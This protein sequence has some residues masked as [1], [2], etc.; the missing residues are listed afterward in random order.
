MRLRYKLL[1][2]FIAATLTAIVT[3]LNQMGLI[4]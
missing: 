3:A 4:R 1:A 2:L